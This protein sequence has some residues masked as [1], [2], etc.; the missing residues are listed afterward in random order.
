LLLCSVICQRLTIWWCR[1]SFGPAWSG[2]EQCGLALHVRISDAATYLST[3]FK[4]KS[5]PCVQVNTV[6]EMDFL[7]HHCG[8]VCWQ[9]SADINSWWHSIHE[10][11]LCHCIHLCFQMTVMALSPL[12]LPHFILIPK[13]YSLLLSMGCLDRAH[14]FIC[15][16]FT[17]ENTICLCQNLPHAVLSS[18]SWAYYACAPNNIC[19]FPIILCWSSTYLGLRATVFLYSLLSWNF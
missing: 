11:S 14:D 4:E 1:P 16:C 15:N 10:Q 9:S 5:S 3:K 6:Y 7:S 19:I 18:I 17:S 13:S 12:H 2:S 8:T